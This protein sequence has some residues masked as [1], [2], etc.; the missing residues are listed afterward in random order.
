[1]ADDTAA[2]PGGLWGEPD[3]EEARRVVRLIMEG[4]GGRN[5]QA[6]LA[7]A[8]MVL[9]VRG[10]GEQAAPEPERPMTPDEIRAALRAVN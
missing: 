7:A 2:I 8:K 4:H 6:R 9:G 10:P 3:R 5:A 1:M